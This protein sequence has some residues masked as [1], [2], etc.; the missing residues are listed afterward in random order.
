M[1]ESIGVVDW[2]HALEHLGNA[3][4]LLHPEEGP[5]AS[6]WYREHETALFLGHAQ[7][8]AQNLISAADQSDNP[9]QA[10]ALRKAANAQTLLIS[11]GCAGRYKL[12]WILSR[13]KSLCGGCASYFVNPP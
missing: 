7:R 13:A 1:L 4:L 3:K 12:V 2:C 11:G 9:E 10:E 6:R 5:V 8:V